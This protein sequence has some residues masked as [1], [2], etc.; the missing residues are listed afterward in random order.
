MTDRTE[1]LR[2][3]A[4]AVAD[5]AGVRDAWTA[6]SFTDRLFVVE[7]PPGA[8]LPADVAR[9]LDDRGLRGADEVY[10]VGG[11]ADAAFAGALEDGT[12]YRF[13]DVQTR[14]EHRS[15]VVE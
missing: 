5:R 6:K 12:R 13:V 8:D 7:V 11:A 15:Y 14:G 1:E 10:D 4:E 2:S 3:L 9:T